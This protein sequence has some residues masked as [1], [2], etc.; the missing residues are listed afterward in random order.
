MSDRF[1]VIGSIGSEP[2]RRTAK[3]GELFITFSVASNERRRNDD[4]SWVDVATSWFDVTAFG[5]LARHGSEALHR[6]DRVIVLGDLTV[7]Q[8]V[9]SA[10]NPGR[11][12]KI[13]ATA[14]GHDLTVGGPRSRPQQARGSAGGGEERSAA[15]ATDRPSLGQAPTGRST[16]DH[17]DEWAPVGGDDGS[18]AQQS[19]S[20][21]VGASTFE[22]EPEWMTTPF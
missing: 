3:N 11:G 20:T 12:V 9:T 6:G 17:S 21:P 2:D 14:I 13:K 10:G 1:T 7:S 22:P 19:A 18:A 16:V 4:G 5:A 8:Y 15:S